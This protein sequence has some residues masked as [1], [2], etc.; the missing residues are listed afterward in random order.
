MTST[1]FVQ[2]M[3]VECRK[4]LQSAMTKM[5]SKTCRLCKTIHKGRRGG[6]KQCDLQSFV[7]ETNIEG[8]R[9]LQSAM[10]SHGKKKKAKGSRS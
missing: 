10:K 2:E 7:Q 6:G 9:D 4:G 5:E 8:R 3:Q 1:S